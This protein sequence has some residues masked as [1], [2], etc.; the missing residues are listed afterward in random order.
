MATPFVDSVDPDAIKEKG[1]M[2]RTE[3]FGLIEIMIALVVAAVLVAMSTMAYTRYTFRAR[4]AD[5]HHMLMT[6]AH[7]QERWYATYNRYTDDVGK[8]G[9]DASEALSPHAYYALTLT[10]SDASAQ[11]YVATATPINA[12]A[13]DVCG[14]LTIDNA[15]HKTPRDDD[16]ATNANGHCW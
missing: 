8:L 1:A 16:V 9:Y 14:E 2:E 10:L 6:I 4:R 7:A 13:A 15:G 12:Q 3:G 11:G 5:A